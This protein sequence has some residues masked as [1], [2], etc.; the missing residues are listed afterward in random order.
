[1]QTHENGVQIGFVALDFR[2]ITVSTAAAGLPSLPTASRI[3][4]VI[5]QPLDQPVNYRDDGT[6]PT[7][8]TGLQVPAGTFFVYD[9]DPTKFRMILANTATGDADVRLGYYGL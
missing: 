6:D 3:R 7:S 4:R 5:I 8:T 1:M 2:Q 9:G